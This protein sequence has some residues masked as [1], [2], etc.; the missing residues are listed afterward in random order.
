MLEPTSIDKE[1][2]ESYGPSFVE[3]RDQAIG[4]VQ[5]LAGDTWTDYNEHDPGVTIL[6]Q[7]CYAL[8]EIPYRAALPIAD[9]LAGAT[10]DI[11]ARRHALFPPEDV[12][13]CEPWTASDYRRIILDRVPLV[14]NVWLVPVPESEAEGRVNGL[15]DIRLYLP[16]ADWAGGDAEGMGRAMDEVLSVYARHRALCE[17]VRDVTILEPVRVVVR[18]TVTVDGSRTPESILADVLF[19]LGVTLAPEIP[20]GTLASALGR[21]RTVAEIFDGPRLHHGLIDEAD[22]GPRA[23]RFRVSDLA[24]AMARAGGVVGVRDVQILEDGL[25]AASGSDFV[26]VPPTG[27]LVLDTAAS[28]IRLV[29]RGSPSEVDPERAR[30]ELDRLWTERRRRHP[31]DAEI[32]SLLPRPRGQARD[33]ARYT[34]IQHQFPNVYGINAYGPP[35]GATPERIAQTRQLKG[36]LV[37]FEQL[38]ADSF[39]QLARARDLYSTDPTVRETYFH[40][41]LLG[42]VPDVEPILDAGYPDKLASALEGADPGAPRRGRFLDVLLGIQGDGLSAGDIA[43]RGRTPTPEEAVRAKVA[44]LRDLVTVSRDRGR[45]LDTMASPA[46]PGVTAMEIRCLIELGLPPRAGRRGRAALW[47]LGIL[48]VEDVC[49]P[50]PGKHF[51]GRLRARRWRP[52][53]LL[54]IEHPLLRFGERR[55]RGSESRASLSFRMT[56]AVS[57]AQPASRE[58]SREAFERTAREVVRRNTPLHIDVTTIFLCP[59]AMRRL[60]RLHARW[61]EALAERRHHAMAHASAALLRFLERRAASA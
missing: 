61:R 34:S 35:D 27:I 49:A 28:E 31:L 58:A 13:P 23:T 55:E 52:R 6:E 48:L 14:G 12:F 16:T 3:L 60:A 15:Y 46:M 40:Q 33:L 51:Y 54:V 10:G 53:R 22:L 38:L 9:I 37:V 56:V 32:Q 7:L 24:R 42:A 4:L 25:H 18:A 45:G 8:T 17:D 50:P 39:A 5:A 44:L 1:D 2:P 57:R 41:S 21:G 43:G 36:Y 20:R 11:D 47:D 30:R 29:H 59:R 19:R 26:E